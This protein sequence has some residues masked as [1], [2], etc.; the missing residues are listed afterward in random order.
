MEDVK[1]QKLLA[2]QEFLLK[3][4]EKI[5]EELKIVSKKIKDLEQEQKAK[6]IEDTI[7]VIK[8][9]GLDIKDVIKEIRLGNLD[10]LKKSMT[11][12]VGDND[13]NNRDEEGK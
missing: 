11:G 3:K 2:R 4:K 5:D 10:Y 8:D 6:S 13:V 9:R 1:L 12:E 7:I